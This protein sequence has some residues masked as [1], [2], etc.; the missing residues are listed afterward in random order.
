MPVAETAGLRLGGTVPGG[1]HP[2]GTL[3]GRSAGRRTWVA[4][5]CAA[6][7]AFAAAAPRPLSAQQPAAA[8]ASAY[9]ENDV[10]AAFLYNFGSYVQ[11]PTSP[12]TSEPLTFAVLNA[13]GIEE[14]L[15]QLVEGRTLQERPVRVRRL[16]SVNELEGEEVLFI[17]S[18]QNW[19]LPQIINAVEG[20][21]L[22]VTDAPEGLE[23][24][25]MINFQLIDERVRFEV[26]LPPAEAV[27]LMLSS[28]LLSVALRVETTRCWIE[29][30][31]GIMG[32]PLLSAFQPRGLRTFTR[33][34]IRIAN[35]S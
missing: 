12:D 19:R 20:P 16:R 33:H 29:C 11:W 17:G 31:D 25:S 28:R 27:G 2:Q 24:G 9:S 6:G 10:K 26:A 22:V 34:R 15:E 3:R 5:I 21:T 7:L 18:S 14:A 32:R 13:P 1:D 23:A 30:R 35:R 8:A 4:A